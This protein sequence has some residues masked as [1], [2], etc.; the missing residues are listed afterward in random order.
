MSAQQI[1]SKILLSGS[2][3]SYYQPAEKEID[4]FLSNP[5]HQL[6]SAKRAMILEYG[7]LSFTSDSISSKTNKRNIVGLKKV[8]GWNAVMQIKYGCTEK[9]YYDF[10]RFLKLTTE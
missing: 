1:D 5:C 10:T 3:L 2:D 9:D 4:V 7:L 6:N 8:Q